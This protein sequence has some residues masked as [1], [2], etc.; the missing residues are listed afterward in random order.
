MKNRL[1]LLGI[2]YVTLSSISTLFAFPGLLNKYD[3]VPGYIVDNN[4]QKTVG[5][6]IPGS[7]TD[8]EVKVKFISEGR[9]KP[10]VYKPEQLTAYGFEVEE[11]NDVGRKV[12]RWLHFER[13]ITDYPAKPFGSKTVFI[14]REIEGQINLYCFYI[15]VR[16]N[17]KQP[18]RYIYYYKD[19]S[20]NQI[21]KISEDEYVRKAKSLFNEY[22]ALSSRIGKKDFEYRNLDRMVRDFNYWKVNQHD[23]DTYRV[24]LKEEE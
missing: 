24:A 20:S 7:I 14:Q 21:H 4:G 9:S 23:R 8:N 11:F 13:H 5:Y 18:Y 2:L 19:A 6:I 16:N 3:K 1:V 22:T 12:K 10:I 15:E 17:P